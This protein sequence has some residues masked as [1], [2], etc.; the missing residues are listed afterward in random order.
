[1]H[2][3]KVMYV[4]V[5]DDELQQSQKASDSKVLAKAYSCFAILEADIHPCTT[6]AIDTRIYRN[7][8]SI[9]GPL[10]TSIVVG[11]C[12]DIGSVLPN[13]IQR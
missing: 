10:E 4:D 7:D 12:L 6:I 5:D 13:N 3:F 8:Y 2:F 1:M 9:S 11:V